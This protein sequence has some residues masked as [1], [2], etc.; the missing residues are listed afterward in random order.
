[1]TAGT[2]SR[3]NFLASLGARSAGSLIPRDVLA[4][5]TASTPRNVAHVDR[6]IAPD[7]KSSKSSPNRQVR[8]VAIVIRGKEG[9]A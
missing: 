7:P 5:D 3:R 6:G 9:R 2:H 1:M 8:Q 4:D